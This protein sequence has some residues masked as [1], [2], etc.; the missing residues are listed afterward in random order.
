MY[1]Y[2]SPYVPDVAFTAEDVAANRAGGFTPRQVELLRAAGE[3]RA[4]DAVLVGRGFLVFFAAILVVGGIIEF[5]QQSEPFDIFMAHQGPILLGAALVMLAL[6]GVSV[7]L[8]AWFSRRLSRPKVSRAEGVAE[9]ISQAAYARGMRYMRYELIL[10]QGRRTVKLFR[11][12][13]PA[14]LSHFQ[15]GVRYRVYYVD[16]PQLPILLSAE[17]V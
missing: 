5:T 4:R 3:Q 7:A 15:T 8:S 14:S 6:L 9:T 1:D 10:R 11:L 12:S 16:F 17:Q 2:T 13:S